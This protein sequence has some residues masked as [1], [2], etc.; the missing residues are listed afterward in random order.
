[1]HFVVR[2]ALTCPT[3]HRRFGQ[4]SCLAQHLRDKPDCSVR[5][6]ATFENNP[7]KRQRTRLTIDQKCALLDELVELEQK[8]TPLAQT[9]LTI[10]H[11]GVSP[12]NVSLWSSLRETLFLSRSHGFGHFRT[13][14]LASRVSFPLQ[15]DNLYMLFVLRRM[16]GGEVHEQWLKDNM[17]TLLIA[18]KP[19]GWG[20]FKASNGWIAGFKKR[21]R[22]TSRCQTNKKHLS[23]AAKLPWIQKFHDWLLHGLR[24]FWGWLYVSYGSNSAFFYL[25]YQA[26]SQCKGR[27]SLD[28]A[29][30]R[31]ELE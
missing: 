14:C 23:A 6:R 31:F 2:S 28:C 21:Y 9:V 7:V 16:E 15:E 22:I 25:E 8:G 10:L 1:M 3:C 27:A 26:N 20:D 4:P 12:K 19:P 24:T 30:Q 17:D 29:T 5:W 11:P 18:D 13:L